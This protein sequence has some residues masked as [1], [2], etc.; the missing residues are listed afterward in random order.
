[1][2]SGPL[3]FRSIRVFVSSTFRDMQE[4]RE[5][6]VKRVFP[7]LRRLCEIRGVAWSEVDL[8]WGVT[9]EQ[10]ADGAVL[11]ICLAEIDRSRPY[12]IGLLGQRYGWIPEH[13]PD[14]IAEQLPWLAGLDGTSV[15]EMEI[16]HGVLNDPSAAAHSFF[17]L[18]DP[19]WVNTR[20]ESEQI[21]LGETAST[22]DIASVG[23]DA[24]EAAA[25]H[26]RERLDQ[27]KDR[28]RS[29]GLRTWEYPNPR[30][31]GERV[32]ADFTA[33]IEHLYPLDEVPDALDRDAEA[34]RA[35]G[36]AQLLGQIHRSRSMSRLDAFGS[37]DGQPLL[38]TGDVGCGASAVVAHW[39]RAWRDAH[40]HDVVFEHHVGATAE[41]SDWMA[42][43]ARVIGAIDRAGNVTL[44]VDARGDAASGG[45]IGAAA[46]RAELFAAFARAGASTRRT[47]IVIDGVDLLDDVDGARMLTWL[48][49][50]VPGNVRVVMTATTGSDSGVE[51][52]ALRRGL[53]R[54]VVPPL[55]EEEQRELIVSFLGRYS[56]GLDEVHVARIVSAPATASA[57]FLRTL[58][59]ELRQHGDHFTLGEIIEHYLAAKTLETLF[60]LVLKRYER[61]FERERPGLVADSMRALWAARRGLTEPELLD[62]LGGS[63]QPVTHA[64]WSP[65]VLAAEAGLVTAGG[66]LVF[67]TEPH[68]R[69]VE[70]RYLPD[71]ESK[72]AAHAM[73]AANFARYELGPRV[74]E[75]LPWQQLGA[76]DIDGLFATLSN[77]S[78]TDLA[79]RQSHQDLRRLWRRVEESGRRIVDGYR[80]VIENPG[81]DPETAWE[82]ARL[83]TDAGYPTESMQLNRFIVE[84]YRTRTDELARRRLPAALVNHAVAL[85][86]QGQLRE[87]QPPLQEAI[88]LSR[89]FGDVAAL[90]A[91]LGNLALC[92]RDTGDLDGSLSLFA[93]AEA[94]CRQ[95]DDA[96]GLQAVLG[97]RAQVLRQRGDHP[98]ALAA[99]SE[100]E[101]LCRSIGDPAAVARALAAQGA[102]LSD[103]GDSSSALERFVAFRI[104]ADE[105]GDLRGVAEASINEVDALRQLGLRFEADARAVEAEA[106]IRRI[107][108]EPLLARILDARARSAIDEGRWPDARTLSTEA[109][110][111]AR[112]AGA[113]PALLLALGMLGTARRELGDI[114]GATVAHSE[115]E[116]LAVELGDH[117]ATSVARC[118]L[119][120]IDIVR[121]DLRAALDRYATAEPALVSLHAVT[122]LATLYA[123]RWQI[124][125]RLGNVAG[126]ISDLCNAARA[127][128]NSGAPADAL[129]LLTRGVEMLHAEGNIVESA[130]VWESL[131][132]LA[133]E[134]DDEAALQRALGSLALI[135]MA[136]GQLSVAAAL[137]DEQ[138]SICRRVADPVALASCIGNRA[139]LLRQSGDLDGA[140]RCID[141]QIA[142]ARAAGHGQTYLHGVANRGEVLGLL[143]HGAQ[144]LTALGEARA[145]AE[146]NGLI[147]MV[148]QIDQMIASIR[149]QPD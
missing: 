71:D 34:H 2:S 64:I 62:T 141:E 32:L 29:A 83:V 46:R 108:D 135:V 74:V 21:V 77:G 25:R 124:H 39:L 37:G 144:A 51:R 27:L 100:Q 14:G 95:L 36:Q 57:L 23:A 140:L 91:A 59:D 99:L 54:A 20:P 89:N 115:E 102:L 93:E 5:E 110:L 98:A 70:R 67:A 31:L 134:L 127:M 15:T 104:V 30:A 112:V 114:E 7:Q 117:A 126:M 19:V 80:T 94:I 84:L 28:V 81:S 17:Y 92:R 66:R 11:P 22:E 6:L 88:D 44:Q 82:V 76:R 85:M 120:A 35:F 118:N 10:K 103:T 111:T 41:S 33:L 1:M 49:K 86:A 63:D 75:E 147:A 58:L 43:A 146:I 130:P 69:A 48:P 131:I 47:V 148:D 12:F 68:R 79:Y 136:R 123:N 45:V 149:T 128:T 87:A 90:Q 125:A 8:R 40:P 73:V 122:A 143:G 109:V 121:G 97:N 16:L 132:V 96:F 106:L 105:I 60:A 119:A 9:D 3:A 61:D 142:L 137:F 101:E 138:E 18:R 56:K 139:I 107:S 72:R 42:M 50:I 24:A 4:E 52:E 26:R 129:G 38:V 65:L 13:L 113:R 78:F 145:I 133:R 55:D 116:T 53:P